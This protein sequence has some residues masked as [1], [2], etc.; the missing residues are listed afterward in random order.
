M[1]LSSENRNF[2]IRRLGNQYNL[3]EKFQ[4][5][6]VQF[7]YP[8]AGIRYSVLPICNSISWFQLSVSLV[9]AGA[10]FVSFKVFY[11]LVSNVI[12]CRN[13][14]NS[15]WEIITCSVEISISRIVFSNFGLRD[16]CNTAPYHN[17][18][19]FNTLL[20]NYYMGT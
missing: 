19:P 12:V 5:F 16:N 10:L 11:M 14:T 6:G 4:N 8:V 18:F 2:G 9:Q 15:F 20:P 13:M 17:I 7:S 3:W 1:V